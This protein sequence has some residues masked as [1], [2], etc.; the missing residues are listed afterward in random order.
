MWQWVLQQQHNVN[1]NSQWQQHLYWHRPHVS[2]AFTEKHA[3]P[4]TVTHSLPYLVTKWLT[5]LQATTRAA[6]IVLPAQVRSA[7]NGAQAPDVHS[8][9]SGR[10]QSAAATLESSGCHSQPAK[11]VFVTVQEISQQEKEHTFVL[12]RRCRG[13]AHVKARHASVINCEVDTRIPC[14]LDWNWILNPYMCLLGY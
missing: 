1:D 3:P 5:Q 2:V 10:N 11:V 13:N 7:F 4:V 8:Q 9:W 12:A 6:V 14:S